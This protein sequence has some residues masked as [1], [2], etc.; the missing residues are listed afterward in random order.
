MAHASSPESKT[1]TTSDFISFLKK[2]KQQTYANNANKPPRINGCKEYIY[3]DGPWHYRDYYAGS[4]IFGGMELVRFNDQPI[5]IMNYYGGITE[6]TIANVRRHNV[7]EQEIFTFLK[8]A[9]LLCP[10]E[11]P[12]RGPEEFCEGSWCYR[13][14]PQGSITNF[15]GHEVLT[16]DNDI[17]C[18]QRYMG[19]VLHNT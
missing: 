8:K 5:W 9:L 1:I 4:A 17:V 6:P 11:L 2:A 15:W 13:N 18:E 19:G 14:M 3:Q 16:C 7:S 10:S 12:L